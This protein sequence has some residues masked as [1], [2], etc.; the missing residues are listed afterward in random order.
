[1]KGLNAMWFTMVQEMHQV[2]LE[3]FKALC[4]SKVRQTPEATKSNC[5]GKSWLILLGRQV[6][7]SAS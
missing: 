1:M 7:D 6:C 5:G 3:F 2:I 4:I